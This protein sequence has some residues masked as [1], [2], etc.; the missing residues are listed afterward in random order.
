MSTE[1]D[2]SD[3][4]A[5]A[6]EYV[7]RLLDDA[8]REAFERR[9]DSE[10]A[11]RDLVREWNEQFVQLTE[12][13]VPVTPPSVVKARIERSLFPVAA[14]SKSWIWGWFAGGLVATGIAVGALFLVPILT[15]IDSPAPTLTANVAAEDGSLVIA[16]NFF[17]ETSTLKVSRETGGAPPGR[18][19]ELWLITDG[20]DAP[21][22]LGVLPEESEAQIEVSPLLA[23]QLANSVLAV[24]EEPPG[25]SPT[26]VPTGAVLAVGTITDT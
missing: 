16:A 23:Q 21:T 9:M 2:H 10:P 25:G 15:E 12:D 26:G 18:V 14:T 6:G 17:S 13:V 3:D 19:L 20:A 22:S 5:L 24:S 8:E 11:L 4:I 1:D 7:L